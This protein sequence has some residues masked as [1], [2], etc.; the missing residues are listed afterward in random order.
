M[1]VRERLQQY[2]A[3]ASPEQMRA[4]ADAV[5]PLQQEVREVLSH[6]RLASRYSAILEYELPMESRRPDVILLVGAGVMVIELKGK[7]EPSQADLD[8][9]S[10]YARDLRCYHRECA[11]REVVPVLVPTRARGYQDLREGVHIT[12]PDALDG[13]VADLA[14]RHPQPV[15]DRSAFLAD[16]AY[17]PLPTLVAAAREL[18]RSG[19]LRRI[20]RAHAATAPTVEEISRIVHVAAATKSRHLILVTG[21]PGAGK[22]LVGLQAVHAKYLDDLSVARDGAKPSAP[23]VFLSGNA[24]LVEVLQYEFRDAGGDGKTF[25]RHV[26]DYVKRYSAKRN[27]VPPEHVLVFDEAQRAFDA[28]RTR[29]VQKSEHAESEPTEF[30]RFADRIPEWCVVIGL[31]GTGQEIHIGEEAG[32]GQWREAVEKSEKA[33]EW[34]IHL[35]DSVTPTFASSTV[36]IETRSVLA[37]GQELR[38]HLAENVHRFVASMLSAQPAE[39]L[40]PLGAA[41]SRDGFHL[42]ITRSLNSAKAY[43]RERYENNPDARYGLIASSKDKSLIDFGVPNDFQS[44]KRVR[45]GPWYAN[46]ENDYEGHSCRLLEECVTEF[47]AQGLEL[48]ATLLAWGTDLRMANGAWSNA[49]ARNYKH[50]TVVKD[51]FQLRINAYR[52]LLTRGRDGCVIFVPKISEMDE[53]FGYLRASG[54]ALL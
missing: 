51:A 21:L 27:P 1:R 29:Q 16:H 54:F 22:T 46:G 28:E 4:W 23:A 41:L 7:L 38:F 32:I 9:A 34:T 25:V 48:D 42:R 18:M 15:L 14:R 20:E 30:I 2:I 50:G 40:A 8:Q 5:P 37:L 33:A 49:D 43:L 13:L 36:P 12:G 35:P 24:P 6:D 52:V 26:R 39:E 53:T 3:D 19:Q 44:T 11:T 45:F 17:Q 31:I 10:A 47:G